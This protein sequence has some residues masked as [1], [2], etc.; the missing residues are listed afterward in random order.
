MDAQQKFPELTDIDERH[1]TTP[2]GSLLPESAKFENHGNLSAVGGRTA[3][4]L[5][6]VPLEV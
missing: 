6:P 3:G 2:P 5:L 1:S 4:R